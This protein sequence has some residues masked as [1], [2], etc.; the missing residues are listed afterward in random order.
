[1]TNYIV[2]KGTSGIGNRVFAVATGI[3]YAQLS[4]RQLVV[5]WR[6]GSYSNSGTNLFFRYFDC[7][8]AQSVEVL[9]ATDSIY[10]THWQNKLNRSLGSVINE[11][12]LSCYKDLSFD[13]SRLDYTETIIVLSAYTH[14]I[15]FMRPLFTGSA[16]RFASMNNLEILQLVLQSNLSL[17]E[18]IR[19]QVEEFKREY[20]A[21]YMIGVHIRY[22][23]MKVP[24]SEVESSLASIIRSV[25]SKHPNYK[26]FVATDSQEVLSSFKH[27]FPVIISTNKWFSAS[28]KRL[29][30]N[31]EEC[32]D[33]I[34]NG[35]EA[36]VDLDLLAACDELLFASRSSFGLLSSMLMDKPQAIRHD[37]D[38]Q[39]PLIK[40]VQLKL[41]NLAKKL[42]I[43]G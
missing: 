38:T 21:D 43:G 17:K 13:V 32:E 4:G 33:L 30:Q 26:I 9:P 10:P 28:G 25:K 18:D 15:G 42:K 39:K 20:F 40:R 22:S 31:P 6:D 37:I 29:H 3:L 8:V 7:P 27:K 5:D 1:M 11:S 35:I 24:L 41:K 16:S 14:K 19:L 2:V 36:L 12:G 23:D 34:Q